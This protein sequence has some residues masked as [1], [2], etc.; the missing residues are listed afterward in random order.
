MKGLIIGGLCGMSAAIGIGWVFLPPDAVWAGGLL[1][2]GLTLV[3]AF[4]GGG[5]SG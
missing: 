1:G 2:A 3:G 4:L 5:L